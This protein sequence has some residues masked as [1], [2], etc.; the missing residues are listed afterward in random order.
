MLWTASAKL[1][2]S[3]ETSVVTGNVGLRLSRVTQISPTGATTAGG[4]Q[5]SA[6]FGLGTSEQ[7]QAAGRQRVTAG[8]A[9]PAW[10]SGGQKI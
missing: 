4:Q 5:L 9:A 7:V 6:S 10:P 3:E 8:V 2:S 1:R